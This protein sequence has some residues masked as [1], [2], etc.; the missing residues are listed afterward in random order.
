MRLSAPRLPL[1]LLSL[2]LA[3]L[4][5]AVRYGGVSVPV[6]GGYLFESLGIAYLILLAGNVFRGM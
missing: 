5:V 1:F 3:I 4:V 2:V 6:V